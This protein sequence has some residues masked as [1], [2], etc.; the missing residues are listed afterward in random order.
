MGAQVAD[1]TD[2]VTTGSTMLAKYLL[3]G[4]PLQIKHKE[5]KLGDRSSLSLSKVV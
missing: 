3:Y 1:V 5:K 2:Q 4:I